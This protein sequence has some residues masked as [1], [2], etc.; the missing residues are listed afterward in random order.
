[1][2]PARGGRVFE[3]FTDE[4]RRIVVYAQEECRLL[5]H[6]HIGTEHLLLALLH[7]DTSTGAA[8]AADGVTLVRARDRI[9]QSGWFGT[10]EP[11]GHVPFTPRAKSMLEQSLRHAER[12]GQGQIAAPH[13]LLAL[14]DERDSTGLRILVDLGADP[15]VLA[16]RAEELAMAGGAESGH[17]PSVGIRT[18]GRPRAGKRPRWLH[19]ARGSEP[20]DEVA[21]TLED[22]TAQR[23]ALANAVR[24]Y[25]RHDEDCDPTRGCTCGLQLVLDELDPPESGWKPR[26]DH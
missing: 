19:Y 20:S 14:L 3:R 26:A 16:V 7:D 24:R 2:L 4:A 18:T 11:Q 9:E 8:L 6:Q 5:R 23:H 21:S 12:L 13:L 22:L 25:G 15:D 10:M 17:D 1:M